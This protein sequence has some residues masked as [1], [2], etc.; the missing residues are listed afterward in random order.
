MANLVW[1]NVDDSENIKLE[2]AFCSVELEQSE[3]EVCGDSIMINFEEMTG[4]GRWDVTENTNSLNKR[5]CDL[6]AWLLQASGKCLIF[7]I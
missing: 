6:S 1:V 5:S 4:E 3:I 7:L 2:L